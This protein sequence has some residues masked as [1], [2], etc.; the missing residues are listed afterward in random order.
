MREALAEATLLR[1]GVGVARI[2][3]GRPV[4]APPGVTGEDGVLIVPSMEERLVLT[5]QPFVKEE[6]RIRVEPRT[7]TF[8]QPVLLRSEEVEVTR[9]G[10]PA[11]GGNPREPSST[12]AGGAAETAPKAR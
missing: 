11:E 12:A 10:P 4:A 1:A 8:R 2:P 7:E 9:A 5:R 3:V 6:L